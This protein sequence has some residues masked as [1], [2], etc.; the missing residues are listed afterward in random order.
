MWRDY[1]LTLGLPQTNHRNLA[2]SRLLMEACNFFWW[3]LS[4]GIGRSIA[5]L[6]TAAGQPVYATIYFVE[7][8]FPPG[9]TLGNFTLD[10]RMRFLVGVRSVSN[11]A[12]DGR[13]V[14][15]RED[16]LG[17]PTDPEALWQ[18]SY[19]LH[20][21][22]HFGSLFATPDPNSHQL[23][24]CPPV[25][26]R[27]SELPCL[28]S[29][30]N[31]TRLVRQAQETSRLGLVPED[32]FALDP[33]GPLD[34]IMAID[35]DRDT[36]AAGLVYFA[37]F[38][39]FMER[40]ERE[41]IPVPTVFGEFYRDVDLKERELLR[42]RTAYFSN[43]GF[44]DRL[45]ISVSRFAPSKDRGMLG[46]RYRLTRESDQKLICLSEAIMSFT[47]HLKS[48]ETTS[49]RRNRSPD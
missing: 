2:E 48:E 9:Q 28:P 45:I 7:E 11:R 6:R 16:C 22:I 4:E 30:E 38:I 10:D 8:H 13:I 17:G 32:W 21:K 27:F 35:P 29:E 18:A 1:N 20:P 19:P 26:A 49:L 25:N 5:Q 42:R 31:P 36:N 33:Q 40:G 37:N 23:E 14:F 46:L 41:A 43:L 47:W 3:S 12:T 34:T 15:D 44:S 39:S 24:P